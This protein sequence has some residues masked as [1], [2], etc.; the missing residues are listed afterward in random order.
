MTSP[1]SQEFESYVPVYD[2]VPQKWEDAQEFLVEALKEMSNAINIRQ[3]GWY[4]DE[5]LL[6]GKAFIPISLPPGDPTPQ[7]FRAVLRKV[8]DTGPLPNTGT[9]SVPHG[10]VFDNNFTLVQLYG[11]ATDPVA[12]AAIGLGFAS[13]VPANSIELYIDATNINITTG[14]NRSNYTRS[15]VTIEYMQEI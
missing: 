15:F 1:S 8:V 7:Q 9:K 11:A 3:I 6:S 14:I 4:L 2:S 12:F 5:E 13:T 10:I